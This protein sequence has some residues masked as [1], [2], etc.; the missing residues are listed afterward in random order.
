MREILIV[1]QRE[2][3][4]RVR[5][6]AFLI[7]TLTF[8][9]LF[10]ALLAMPAVVED[11]P[12]EREIVLVDDAPAGVSERVVA[13]LREREE[14]ANLYDVEV[15]RGTFEGMRAEL[16]Q[17]VLDESI[18]GWLA[19]P[20]DVLSE[21]RIQYRARNIA[22]RTVLRDLRNAVSGAVQAVR[23]RDAGLEVDE[24]AALVRPV[25]VD[26]AQITAS[27]EEGGDAFTTFFFAYAVTFLIYFITFFY[28][29]AVMRSVLEEKTNRIS[30]VLVSSVPSSRLLAGKIMG[31]SAAAILQVGIWVVIVAIAVL[32]SDAL[33]A[34]FGIPTEVFEAI[35]IPVGAVV[36]FLAFFLLGFVL[37][38]S[39]FAALGAAVT[40]EHEAQSYQFMLLIPLI[41][42]MLFLAA[43]TGEPTGRIA[44]T[45]GMV[46]F[47]AP[48][49]MPMRI[50]SAPIPAWQIVASLVLIAATAMAVAWL[51]GKIYRVGMLSTGKKASLKDLGRWLRAS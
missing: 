5:S 24:V 13:T 47:T 10:I 29:L 45:L 35:T 34:R 20:S 46:P 49:A 36:Q 3:L 2:F 4:E 15:V 42:P 17:R 1:L 38:S 12:E 33:V 51:A 27:G 31:V 40:S 22:N 43:I 19:L 26:E 30:E 11:R 44:T 9:V 23:L 41:V 7:G 21:N 37:F 50:A 18:D 8:P 6:R 14:G 48:V 25:S 16:N 39:M 32:N 28:S